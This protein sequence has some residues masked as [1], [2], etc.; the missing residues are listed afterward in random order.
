ME[1]GIGKLIG[2]RF[3]GPLEKAGEL[4]QRFP[5]GSEFLRWISQPVHGRFSTILAS[6]S[7]SLPRLSQL[8]SFL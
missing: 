6:V 8:F 5:A 2:Q 4:G 1:G 7:A 3:P